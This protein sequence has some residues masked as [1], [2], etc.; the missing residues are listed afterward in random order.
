MFSPLC[1]SVSSSVKQKL[2][3]TA[4]TSLDFI[5]FNTCLLSIYYVLDIVLGP[6]DDMAVIETDTNSLVELMF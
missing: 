6:G 4:F 2:R 5:L 3:I 1:T